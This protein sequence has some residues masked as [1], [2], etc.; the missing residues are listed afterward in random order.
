MS[1]ERAARPGAARRQRARVPLAALA[2]TAALSAL[3]SARRSAATATRYYVGVEPADGGRKLH[4][5]SVWLVDSRGRWQ[6]QLEG[7]IP[8]NPADLAFDLRT[9]LKS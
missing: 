1:T 2:A 7:G 6:G 8:I 9:L 4:S 5:A 3:L